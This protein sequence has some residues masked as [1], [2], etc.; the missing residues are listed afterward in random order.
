MKKS[1]IVLTSIGLLL[2]TACGKQGHTLSKFKATHET[3][4]Q[5]HDK[6]D[7]RNLKVTYDEEVLEPH[8]YVLDTSKYNPKKAGTYKINV[9][10]RGVEGI[11]LDIDVQVSERN[12]ANILFIGNASIESITSHMHEFI[13]YADE[14]KDFRIYRLEGDY[15]SINQHYSHYLLNDE[16]YDLYEY[17][18]E[19][20]SW[21]IE[22]DISLQSALTYEGIEW[23]FVLLQE[24]NIE[25]SLKDNHYQASKL[26]DV[27]SGHLEKNEKKIP[28]YA[29]SMP[30]AYQDAVDLGYDYYEFF[31]NDQSE[32]YEA[33][34]SESGSLA[35]VF[36]L[37]LPLGTA[38]QNA[39]LTALEDDKD[40]TIDGM[41]LNERI[42]CP[43]SSI[44]LGALFS[45]SPVEEFSYLG[46]GEYLLNTEEQRL[47][48]DVVSATIDK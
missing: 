43:L 33:I 45:G 20:S 9:S 14:E 40:L 12:S 38:V 19:S 18:N 29:L 26:M 24:N 44:L 10:L 5:L 21:L 31:A 1:L 8:Q 46:E 35:E 37:V 28:A 48:F 30:W 6:F 25:A 2:L 11:S 47:L 27:I 39:R 22:E 4:Y 23:D 32:M 42:G 41:M 15:S 17:D 36:D 34:A 16:D 3:V 7:Y 13:N